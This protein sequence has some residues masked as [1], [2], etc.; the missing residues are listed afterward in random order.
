MEEAKRKSTNP[1]PKRLVEEKA[2]KS[3]A[4]FR[5]TRVASCSSVLVKNGQAVA[6]PFAQKLTGYKA[7]N[8]YVNS[9]RSSEVASMAQ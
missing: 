3:A 7:K 4:Q 5:S 2:A 9:K 8:S 6:V 1:D